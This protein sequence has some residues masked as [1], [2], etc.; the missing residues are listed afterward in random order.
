MPA[1]LRCAQGVT[2]AVRPLWCSRPSCWE[3]ATA[4]L[5][6][7]LQLRADEAFAPCELLDRF[8]V[9]T[10]TRSGA[11]YTFSDTPVPGGGDVAA[12]FH[13]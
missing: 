10:L 11:I 4:G 8:T 1:D 3:Q 12:V 5:P 9:D 6:R 7:V 2:T 13:Y